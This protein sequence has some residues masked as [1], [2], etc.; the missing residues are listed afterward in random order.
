MP[1]SKSPEPRRLGGITPSIACAICVLSLATVA[2]TRG[3]SAPRASQWTLN[4]QFFTPLPKS[5]A[6]RFAEERIQRDPRLFPAADDPRTVAADDAS[7]L[8]DDDEVLGFVVGGHARAYPIRTISYHHIVNDTL[9][10]THLTVT[11]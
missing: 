7:F 4:R 2:M 6:E 8:R 5:D 9:S 1:K 10:G 11:Y 3:N